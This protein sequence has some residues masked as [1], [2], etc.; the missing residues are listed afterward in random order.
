MGLF[1]RRRTPTPATAVHSRQVPFGTRE[2]G[3]KAIIHVAFEFWY[4]ESEH[5]RC[6]SLPR[7]RLALPD[8]LYYTR[9]S[10]GVAVASS[11]L[12]TVSKWLYS[13]AKMPGNDEPHCH[14]RSPP[15][16]P[17]ARGS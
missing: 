16:S 17:R 15:P 2:H 9:F 10:S 4:A 6:F 12:Y 11:R 5:G 8:S 3:R 7:T 14:A 1:T 13:P